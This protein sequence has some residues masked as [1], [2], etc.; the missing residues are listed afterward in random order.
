MDYIRIM[1]INKNAKLR[2]LQKA[3]KKKRRLS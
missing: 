3:N 2:K 1:K